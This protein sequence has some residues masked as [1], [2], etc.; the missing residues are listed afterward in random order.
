MERGGLA[1]Q[2][3]AMTLWMVASAGMLPYS[4]RRTERPY[5]TC[6]LHGCDNQTTHNGGYCCAEH[7]GRHRVVI[8]R[9]KKLGI[10]KSSGRFIFDYKICSK[11]T[12]NYK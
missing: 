7:C 6:L 9:L 4:L 2:Y 11:V 5:K 10:R 1:S 8:A 12:G 3:L